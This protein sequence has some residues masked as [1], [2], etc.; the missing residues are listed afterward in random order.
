M[1]NL[2]DLLHSVV[3]TE[4]LGDIATTVSQIEFDSR[5]VAKGSLFV[6]IRGTQTD[7]HLFIGQAIQQ[8]AIAVVCETIP[9]ERN[10]DVTY[11]SVR[12]SQQALAYIAS[13]FYD[14]PSTRLK[15]IGV[16]GTNG[17]TTVATLL[18]HLFE[19]LGYRCGLLST[20]RNIAVG[21]DVLSTL[22]T[23]DA[24]SIN[25]LLNEMCGKGITHCFMEVSSHS[26]VQHRVS[27]L[28]FAGGIFTNITQDHLDYHGTFGAYLK[29]KKTFFDTLPSTAYALTNIDDRN[30]MVILQNT[31][32]VRYSYSL[33]TIADFG[34]RIV[35]NN[36]DGLHL[37]ISGTDV[38]VKLVGAF[39][40][41]NLLA[42]YAAAILL[43]EDAGQVLLE[44][45][46][47]D[48]IEGRFQWV[49]NAAGTVGIVDYA[50]TPDAL[51]NVL[52][53]INSIRKVDQQII[54]VIGA[55]GN[56][57]RTKRP[58]MAKVTAMHS[59]KVILTSDNPRFEDPSAIIDEMLAELHDEMQRKV[60][61]IENRKE[62]IRVACSLAQPGD[63]ILVAGKGHEK[64]QEIRGVKYPFDDMLVL[65]EILNQQ[66]TSII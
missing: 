37:S 11:V 66:G 17:K 55:G 65:R 27:G 16:T 25:K 56:R 31:K 1:K 64:Y 2:S 40:A 23:P 19:G 14:H 15:L 50:H 33:R 18:Y 26:V 12:D 60:L 63:I 21:I 5:R 28:H 32:A 8:G 20:I 52:T 36:L 61:R 42:V 57:D 10:V 54:S 47:L 48:P 44:L 46:R 58:L 62:A 4:V 24:L 22:T 9:A 30:G 53:T 35:E 45:S 51:E 3:L 6:A 39:N 38:Y 29:A 49:K 7:G 41:Y 43:G 59:H 34:C 13:N